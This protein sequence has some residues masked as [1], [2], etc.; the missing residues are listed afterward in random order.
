[1]ADRIGGGVFGQKR[2]VIAVQHS[3]EVQV[4]VFHA[5]FRNSFFQ[6]VERKHVRV[7]ALETTVGG[8]VAKNYRQKQ[9]N[10]GMPT[11]GTATVTESDDL[12]QIALRKEIIIIEWGVA[13][14]V[15]CINISAMLK[16]QACTLN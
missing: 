7:T 12:D 15:F 6:E 1:M 9:L 2:T 5:R 8:I 3:T 10:D 11:T 13:L 14:V 16:K 4:R